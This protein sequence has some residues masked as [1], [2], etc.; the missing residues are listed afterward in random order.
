MYDF[1]KKKK[2]RGKRRSKISSLLASSP[3]NGSQSIPGKRKKSRI[4]IFQNTKINA[5]LRPSF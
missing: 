4:C 1:K 5:Q 3:P 2:E